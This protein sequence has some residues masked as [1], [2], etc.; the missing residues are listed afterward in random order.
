MQ[1]EGYFIEK[2]A[3]G[4]GVNKNSLAQ[5]KVQKVY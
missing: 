1:F 3:Q 4:N 2:I 5:R